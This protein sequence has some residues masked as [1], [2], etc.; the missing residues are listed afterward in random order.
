VIALGLL[1]WWIAAV[2]TAGSGRHV[3]ARRVALCGPLA[4][5]IHNL[6]DFNLEFLGVAAPLCALAGSLSERRAFFR[7]PARSALV[8][9][10]TALVGALLLSL[11]ALP[12]TWQ[13]RLAGD[14][15]VASGDMSPETAQR[16]RPLDA[17]LHILLAQRAL[18]AGDWHQARIR[19][20][21]AS[22][23][24]PANSD[25]WLR[26]AHAARELEDKPTA[27]LAL[28]RALATV[29]RPP[30]PELARYLLDRYPNAEELAALMPREL[31]PW[32]MVMESL[33]A[34]APA[35]AAILAAA[36]SQV[37]GREAP[38]MQMQVRLALALDN[39]AL[40][41]HYAR[42]LRTLAP[43]DVQSYLLFA[44]ALQSQ[45]VPRERELQRDL[46]EVL[47]LGLIHDPAEVALIEE[48][49]ITSLLRD[50]QPDALARA[51]ELMPRLLARPGDRAALQRR[52]ALQRALG[53]A[54][55]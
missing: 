49:L 28:A 53:Q 55:S 1:W 5:A 14:A 50:G 8:G 34:E 24:Q 46:E 17:S 47:A 4:L 26:L 9:G 32:T 31:A 42:L 33:V 27:A 44:R 52:H 51:R 40:A 2:Y 10:S 21:V 7:V 18:A 48:T 36:R 38:V 23:L 20:T 19:A 13:N 30:E 45:K 3:S 12:H 54:G 35:Y 6:A 11:W 25:A 29:R 39:P 22:Q 41:L 37:D 43:H 16:M 15:A